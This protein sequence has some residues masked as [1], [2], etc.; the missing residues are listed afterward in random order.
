VYPPHTLIRSAAAACVV[1]LGLLVASC[2]PAN[3]QTI[4]IA[5]NSGNVPTSAGAL[6]I[7]TASGSS[8]TSILQFDAGEPA[9]VTLTASSSISAPANA[10]SP[11]GTAR[12][13][14]SN[15]NAASTP[16]P[17]A[18]PFYWVTFTV[19]API[20]LS[21]IAAETLAPASALPVAGASYFDEL[22]N[23]TS[24]ATGSKI[25]SFGPGTIA[26]NI[27]TINSPSASVE[28]TP[29]N[30]YMLQFY[31]VATASPS[32]SP[33]PVPLTLSSSSLAFTGGEQMQSVTVT[34]PGYAGSFT[35]SGCSG[36]ATA[37]VA[38]S[39]VTVSSV[40]AGSCTLTVSD[41]LGNSANL[42]VGVTVVSVP[43][44]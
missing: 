18:V 38:G 13:S 10:I 3:V 27:L 24:G 14:A 43:V 28:L 5:T 1:A 30:T 17:N 44:Q 42:A 39:T 7:P 6:P 2:G 40:S 21:D 4:P 32:P 41:T 29:G 36:I 20:S 23:I 19:S 12:A 35:T 37:V 8:L 16:L 11:S 9:G 26:N 33:T 31:Y 15:R 25:A 22:D 34:D